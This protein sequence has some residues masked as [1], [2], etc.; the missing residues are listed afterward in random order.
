MRLLSY[1]FLQDTQQE[2]T[3]SNLTNLYLVLIAP[4]NDQY[5]N[6]ML[7]V[8]RNPNH[9]DDSYFLSKICDISN[10]WA[11][12]LLYK[13]LYRVPQRFQMHLWSCLLAKKQIIRTGEA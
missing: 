1:V 8:I 11:A 2:K 9:D 5:E 10:F 12:K 6:Q 3:C 4:K 13:T 7:N